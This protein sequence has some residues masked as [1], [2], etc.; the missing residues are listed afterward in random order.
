MAA[1]TCTSR[2][3]ISIRSEMRIASSPTGSFSTRQ[4]FSVLPESSGLRTRV[5]L[6]SL[7]KNSRVSRL[8]RGVICEAQDTATGSMFSRLCK[9]ML[10]LD[11]AF[12]FWEFLWVNSNGALS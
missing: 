4:M 8:R 3:P 7:S 12:C 9:S 2:P 1:Y 11:Y 6:S 10:F 5:S